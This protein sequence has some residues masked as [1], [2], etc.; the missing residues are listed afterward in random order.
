M[1]S[2]F[3]QHDTRTQSTEV[4]VPFQHYFTPTEDPMVESRLQHYQ[5]QSQ[6]T[7][8]DSHLKPPHP[9]TEEQVDVYKVYLKTLESAGSCS[10]GICK[11]IFHHFS[12]LCRW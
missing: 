6:G 3:Q 8:V 10:V 12:E 4:Y 9:P 11:T 1:E 2:S 7:R 5:T